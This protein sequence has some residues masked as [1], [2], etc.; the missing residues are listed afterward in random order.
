NPRVD[1]FGNTTSTAYALGV[2]A[3]YAVNG[4]IGS[5]TDTDVFAVDLKCST[6]MTVD[7]SGIGPQTAVDLKLDVLDA[8]G[9]T[10][11]TSSPASGYSGSPPVSTGMNA[12]VE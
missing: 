8:S 6:D 4:I 3:S 12:S 5:R 1:D 10:V 2:Q 11:A 9:T 7:V